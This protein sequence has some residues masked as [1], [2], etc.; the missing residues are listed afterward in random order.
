MKPSFILLLSILIFTTSTSHSQ[1]N[2]TD[3]DIKMYSQVWDEVIN[4]GAIDQINS[5][6][7]DENITGIASPQN[8]VGIEAFKAYYQ[9]FLTGFSER[10]FEIKNIFGQGDQIVKHWQFKGK[11]TGE[12]FGIPPTARSVNIEGVTLVKMKNGKIL[13]EQD[14]MDNSVFM[15]QLGLAPNP[16]N[17]PIIDQLYT[18]FNKGEIPAV[19]AMMDTRIVWNEASSSYYSDGNPYTSPD[20]ILNG[21]FKRIG[22]DND[23]F[24]LENIKLTALGNN[25]VLASLNYDFKSKKTGERNKTLVV[26][27]WTIENGKIIAFQQY[28]GLGK[29]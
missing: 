3:K 29:Q 26:H 6:Y 2:P 7:F 9:N 20:S 23:Y 27:E 14:F 28:L 25:K 16:N 12:F 11:H 24:N 21:V 8:I 1:N 22:E 19:L 5:T 4:K 13:Q 10:S 17:V 18:H 15:Q